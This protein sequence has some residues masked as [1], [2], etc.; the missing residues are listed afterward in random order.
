MSALML[1]VILF[2]FHIFVY[3]IFH[4]MVI[5]TEQRVL[6]Q[7]LSTLTDIYKS[8]D[9]EE[10]ELRNW[11][12]SWLRPFVDEGQAFR[13]ISNGRIEWEVNRGIPQD[14]FLKPNDPRSSVTEVWKGGRKDVSVLALPLSKGKEGRV[15]LYTDFTSL[16]RYLDTMLTALMIGSSILLVA[17]AAGGYLMS[18]IALNPVKRTIRTVRELDPA[19]LESRL[20]VP[21]TNDEIEELSRTFNRLLDRI[22]HMMEQQ[23]RFTADASH[24]LKT[25]VSVIR[26]YVNLLNRWGKENPQVL[27]EALEAIDQETDR[28]ERM[29]GRLLSLARL[30]GEA[31]PQKVELT[32][33][34][35]ITRERV[36]RWQQIYTGR[37]VTFIEDGAIYTCIPRSDWEELVDILLDNAGKYSTENTPVTVTLKREGNHVLFTVRDAGVGIPEKELNRVF[38]RFYRTE[39]SRG[40]KKSGSGLGLSIAQRIV[41]LHEG[42]ITIDSRVGEWTEVKV[43]LPLK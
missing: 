16:N 38:E 30:E 17:V 7:K 15:E 31:P 2:L 18:S 32:D 22:Y 14:V 33:L 10:W 11:L 12:S 37:E 40:K 39:Q 6:H 21:D 23:R 35:P 3:K 29:T 28:I 26:G 34:I 8:G 9:D 24:E 1:I 5:E 36:R 27:K 42:E 4:N 41:Q 43:R 13:V 20:H 25:P 19:R